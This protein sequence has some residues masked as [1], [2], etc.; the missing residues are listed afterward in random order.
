MSKGLKKLLKKVIAKDAQEELAVADAK[1]GS[2]IKVWPSL[3]SSTEAVSLLL[4]VP[5]S[6]SHGP[7]RC[8]RTDRHIQTC[9]HTL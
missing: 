4:L 6:C 9:T 2:M 3:C 5:F 7:T 8:T 1:L